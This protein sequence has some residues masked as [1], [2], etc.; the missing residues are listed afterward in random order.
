MTQ[1]LVSVILTTYDR[2][3]WLEEALRSALAQTHQPLEVIVVSDGPL[4]EEA[5]R[6]E[7]LYPK[8][9]WLERPHGGAGAARNTGIATST[10]EFIQ[11]L[12]D[13]DWLEPEAVALKVNCY[14]D[15]PE[16]GCVYSDI[17]LADEDGRV[18]GTH[19]DGWKRPLPTGDIYN[20]LL[21]RNIILVN[22]PLWLKG[23]LE[24]VGGFPER[25]GS[26]DWECL[27]RCAEFTRFA[28]IDKPLGYYRLHRHNVTLQFDQQIRGDGLAQASF[29]SGARFSA[30]PRCRRA[31]LLSGYA[32]QQW[33]NG[34]EDLGMRFLSLAR[35][36]DPGHPFVIALQLL[37][38]IGRPLVRRG[39][40]LVWNL[41]HRVRPSSGYYFLTR[42]KR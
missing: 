42:S 31:R 14:T 38:V 30:L 11:F 16:I 6:L 22:S 7:R 37:R 23:I 24:Q 9:R 21:Q 12:D 5:H 2:P 33:L 1:P 27:V 39:M 13:D 32:F 26:E 28:F 40:R 18:L 35:Q 20:A 8:V 10:G 36:A 25:T 34:D 15:H 4:T 17:Y 3:H 19:F 29:I 41:R